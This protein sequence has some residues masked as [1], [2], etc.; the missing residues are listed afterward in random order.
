MSSCITQGII[1]L[2]F[3]LWFY[4]SLKGSRHQLLSFFLLGCVHWHY[5][6]LASTGSCL[7]ADDCMCAWLSL[8][9]CRW[10]HVCM[11]L[12]VFLQIAVC[13]Q[14]SCCL[15]TDDCMCA[16]LMLLFCRWLHACMTLL[17]F[18]QTACT[19]L[20]LFQTAWPLFPLIIYG[21]HSTAS[22]TGPVGESYDMG[23]VLGVMLP[24]GL[25]WDRGSW[26][27][28]VLV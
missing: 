28:V 11:S 23:E 24:A 22:S 1:F 25:A 13:V 16:G 5:C 27:Y 8:S 7:S 3:I 12:L 18:L 26:T 4:L 2:L 10:L 14:D 20:R 9:F 15:S 6:I 19:F 21:E 17:V